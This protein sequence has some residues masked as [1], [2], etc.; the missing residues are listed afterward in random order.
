M[1][2]WWGNLYKQ[3]AGSGSYVNQSGILST[4]VICVCGNPITNDIFVCQSTTGSIYKL[5]GGSGSFAFLNAGACSYIS[6]HGSQ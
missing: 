5:T 4:S 2:G 3:T 1:V 6:K